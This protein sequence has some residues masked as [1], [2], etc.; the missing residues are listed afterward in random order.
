MSP[1]FTYYVPTDTNERHL[2]LIV[3]GPASIKGFPADNCVMVSPS[4][5]RQATY[6]QG[7]IYEI[8]E[9]P[10]FVSRSFVAYRHTKQLTR[11]QIQANLDAGHFTPTIPFSAALTQRARDGLLASFHTPGWAKEFCRACP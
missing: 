1:G 2:F 5:I 6:D 3:A 4:T 11:A 9:H 10:F 8:G 7:C